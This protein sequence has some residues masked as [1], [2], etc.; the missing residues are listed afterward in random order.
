MRK[1]IPLPLILCLAACGGPT[2][3]QA[4]VDG[5]P[6]APDGAYIVEGDLRL[7]EPEEL[8]RYYEAQD[9]GATADEAS[10][11]SPLTVAR[12]TETQWDCQPP[13]T[14]TLPVCQFGVWPP[15]CQSQTFSGPTQVR[16]WTC[17]LGASPPSCGW[18]DI[19][20]P[21]P[22]CFPR[23]VT[24]DRVWS[25]SERMQISYCLSDDLG[26][27]M[28]TLRTSLRAAARAWERVV[29]V[30]FIH[31]TDLDGGSCNASTNVT[32]D[33]HLSTGDAN[34]ASSFFPHDARSRRNLMVGANVVGSVSLMTHELGH[35]LGFRHEQIRG[36]SLCFGEDATNSRGV[37][38]YDQRSIMHYWQ[39]ECNGTSDSQ[40]EIT[41]RDVQGAQR[42]YG[43]PIRTRQVALRTFDGCYLSAQNNG[44]SGLYAQA[45]WIGAWETFDLVDVAPGQ[46]AL[47]ASGAGQFLRDTLDAVGTIR[48]DRATLEPASTFALI[49]LAGRLYNLRT[50]AGRTVSA[51][52]GMASINANAGGQAQ[53]R[54]E[55]IPLDEREVA[56]QA[57]DGRYLSSDPTPSVT[58]TRIYRSER[59]YLVD[60]GNGQVA[61][62]S[63][64][65]V[66]MR[67][68]NGGGGRVYF[69]RD[70]K[71]THETFALEA[72]PGER[73]FA[74]K[75]YSGRHYVGVS[76]GA[77]VAL[78]G[79]PV[80]LTLIEMAGERISLRAYSGQWVS[81]LGGGGE[82]VQVT[83]TAIGPAESFQLVRID[84]DRTK[85]ALRAQNGQYLTVSANG[86]LEATS[87]AIDGA[88]KLTLQGTGGSGACLWY[89]GN[90]RFVA[91]E[92]G[93]GRELTANRSWCSIWETFVVQ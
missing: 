93:G 68:E 81:A 13:P 46:V 43:A 22:V 33:A 34:W 67:A 26:A 2:D 74:L 76:G 89:P 21:N 47:R 36:S 35:T 10:D 7:Y 6:R 37:T 73:R 18:R 28:E 39:A 31:R 53:N 66:F 59:L 91:A 8:A 86:V 44:G 3:Y 71:Y 64:S 11:S 17:D 54:V 41:P 84:A 9:T 65:G 55:I 25:P 14:L 90:G 62:R 45:P 77:V 57:P 88:Q 15:S 92:N 63:R 20:L 24:S 19:N 32:F 82:G 78:D 83:G 27:R 12:I 80:A 38:T 29:P 69:D 48:A 79:A 61:L 72:Q 4:F 49:P 23:Q 70:I 58:S 85:V 51:A 60:L 40:Q 5:L 42:L 75:T 1:P 50:A 87:D 56:L 30:R 16:V 52:C